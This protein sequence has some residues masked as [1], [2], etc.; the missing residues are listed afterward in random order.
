VTFSGLHSDLPFTTIF[1]LIALLTLLRYLFFPPGKQRSRFLGKD[2]SHSLLVIFA[3]VSLHAIFPS[4]FSV[5]LA[6]A[7]SGLPP[8]EQGNP[9]REL[10]I[11]DFEA[12]PLHSTSASFELFFF[13]ASYP[14]G[15]RLTSHQGDLFRMKVTI[16]SDPTGSLQKRPPSFILFLA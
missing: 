10:T 8:A 5:V 15:G 3:Y 16:F 1:F 9:L 11:G 12:V 14:R 7:P 13:I 2:D 6:V 4:S